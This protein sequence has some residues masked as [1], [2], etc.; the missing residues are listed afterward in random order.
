MLVMAPEAEYRL[1]NTDAVINRMAIS[2]LTNRPSTRI[3]AK[4]V[5]QPKH[6]APRTPTTAVMAREISGDLRNLVLRMN[7]ATI[8]TRM[9]DVLKYKDNVALLTLHDLFDH[10]AA[11]RE[12]VLDDSFRPVGKRLTLQ[13]LWQTPAESQR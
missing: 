7:A 3:P 8:A 6:T 10:R 12:A 1:T 4:L 5:V 9:I 2:R 11:G 13:S